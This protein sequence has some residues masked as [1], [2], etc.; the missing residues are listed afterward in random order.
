MTS[1]YTQLHSSNPSGYMSRDI[2]INTLLK[3]WISLWETCRRLK[4]QYL[5]SQNQANKKPVTSTDERVKGK[6][7]VRNTWLIIHNS[8]SLRNNASHAD[9][10]KLLTELIFF[11]KTP[12]NQFLVPQFCFPKSQGLHL[13]HSNTATQSLLYTHCFSS[14]SHYPSPFQQNIPVAT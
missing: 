7:E 9:S 10:L 5:F 8:L 2:L 12:C 13:A 6:V 14:I 4:A 11:L 1:T 3:R